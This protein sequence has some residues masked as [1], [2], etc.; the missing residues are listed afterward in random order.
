MKQLHSDSLRKT[1]SGLQ[2]AL[3]AELVAGEGE[4]TT[5]ARPTHPRPSRPLPGY[6]HCRT[7][8]LGSW[9]RPMINWYSPSARI[10]GAALMMYSDRLPDKDRFPFFVSM[11]KTCR[12]SRPSGLVTA[13][14]SRAR[15][16]QQPHNSGRFFR[17]S[18]ARLCLAPSPPR[19]SLAACLMANTTDDNAHCGSERQRA[20][21]SHHPQAGPLDRHARQPGAATTGPPTF[22]IPHN[23]TFPGHWPS[24]VNK[25]AQALM[26]RMPRRLLLATF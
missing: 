13:S 10:V 17:V 23:S 9:V 14:A 7:F 24:P 6:A 1:T 4:E 26:L 22:P 12:H 20:G 5:K 25:L 18:L 16:L 15:D 11:S 8:Q 2:S 21:G 19:P 3:K